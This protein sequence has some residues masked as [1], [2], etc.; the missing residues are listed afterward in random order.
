V[1]VAAEP[2]ALEKGTS[3]LQ[4]FVLA[5]SLARLTLAAVNYAAAVLA[6]G[7]GEGRERHTVLE[8]WLA[9]LR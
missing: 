8:V 3:P 9:G 6:A 5:V 1:L 2:F 7:D 4:D